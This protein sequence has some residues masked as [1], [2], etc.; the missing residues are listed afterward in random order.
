MNS[1]T[2]SMRWNKR[3]FN[4]GALGLVAVLTL[5]ACGAAQ[6]TDAGA[7]AAG[8][9]SPTAAASS[10]STPRP[11]APSAAD[12]ARNKAAM[13]KQRPG[14]VHKTVAAGAMK[15]KGAVGLSSTANSG[16]QVTVQIARQ[17]AVKGVARL[18]GEVAGPAV[19]LTIKVKNGSSNA[20]NLDG[21]VVDL[22]DSKGLSASPLLTPPAK[23]I[24]GSLAAG[25][26]ASG[27]YIFTLAPKNR[28][29]CSIRISY[30]DVA[31]VVVFK[32]DLK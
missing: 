32:G 31:P 23:R 25:Q 27:S 14:N 16:D 8:D 10:L 28:K 3:C 20:I 30:S 18:P 21:L 6:A 12:K 24:S 11:K 22:Q 26:T 29:H 4:V 5:S 2:N 13:K 15:V 19:A 1:V 7:R 17:Q 9:S